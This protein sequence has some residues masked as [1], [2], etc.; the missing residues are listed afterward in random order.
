MS[1][2]DKIRVMI[3]DDHDM[4]RN[5]LSILLETCDDLELISEASSGQEAVEI[6]QELRPD[7]VLMDLM[8]PE[9]DGVEATRRIK[10]IS[11]QARIIVLT[12]F[13]DKELVRAAL[14]AGAI[15][16]LLKNVSID[17]LSEAIRAAYAGKSTLTPEARQA[18]KAI[19]ESES[20]EIA[21]TRDELEILALMVDDYS[22]SE[23]A[24]QLGL[25]EGYVNQQVNNIILAVGAASR[26]EAVQ[27]A[28]HYN[29]LT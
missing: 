25:S 9:V 10:M 20:H 19:Q 8:M 11:D 3:V 23:I 28:L 26:S 24:E 12:S 2:Q 7:V 21:L 5:G 6:Y 29:L 14:Q 15:S 16:Y 13:Q 4:V 22:N 27:L 1:E 17:E 18:L